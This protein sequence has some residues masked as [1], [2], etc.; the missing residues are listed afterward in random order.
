MFSVDNMIN[1]PLCIIIISFYYY[2]LFSAILESVGF[3]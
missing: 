3:H 2:Y 1:S